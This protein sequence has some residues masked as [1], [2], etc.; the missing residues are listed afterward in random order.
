MKPRPRT[1][2]AKKRA[3]RG[4]PRLEVEVREP[5]GRASRSGI[6]HEP[7]DI[8]A[9]EARRKHFGLTEEQARDQK[10][11]TAIGRLALRGIDCDGISPKQR[12]AAEKFWQAHNDYLKAMQSPRAYYDAVGGSGAASDDEYASW[13]ENVIE[14]FHGL[15]RAI[16]EAQRAAWPEDL[17]G[18]L[19]RCVIEDREPRMQELG[20]L[21]L[22]LNALVHHFG[23]HQV[24]A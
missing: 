5:N 14:R 8:I 6:R 11:G 21:R 12:L 2:A 16:S 9:L 3:K 18:A 10:G 23:L 4:R 19:Q 1:V 13:C 7:A 17:S 24:E 22:A 15:A 20:T